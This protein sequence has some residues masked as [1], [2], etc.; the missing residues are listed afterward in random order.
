M[1]RIT[2]SVVFFIFWGFAYNSCAETKWVVFPKEGETK[3]INIGESVYAGYFWESDTGGGA[4]WDDKYELVYTGCDGKIVYFMYREFVDSR[5]HTLIIRGD[6]SLPLRYDL[7]KGTTVSYLNLK[8][9]V[10]DYN[11]TYITIKILKHLP[12]GDK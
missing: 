2:M 11:N 6:F 3:P 9:E 8:M 10:L 1:K 12:P 4:K 7:S 5:D